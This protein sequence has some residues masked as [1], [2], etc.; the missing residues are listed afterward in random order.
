MKAACCQKEKKQQQLNDVSAKQI[1]ETEKV[2]V[3]QENT[4]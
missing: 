4:P 3:N 1:I 2:L